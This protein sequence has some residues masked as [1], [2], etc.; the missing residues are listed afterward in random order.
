MGNTAAKPANS[1]ESEGD[2]PVPERY[3]NPAVFNVYN[4]QVNDPNN[5]LPK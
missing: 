1:H 2:C 3:R 4:Q 5:P